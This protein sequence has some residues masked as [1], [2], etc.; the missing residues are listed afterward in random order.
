VHR[1]DTGPGQ[2][3]SIQ[4]ANNIDPKLFQFVL[5]GPSRNMGPSRSAL[6]ATGELKASEDA[7][8]LADDAQV[9]LLC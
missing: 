5:W 6:L 7:K 3:I 9:S 1:W 4:N 8:R 2:V